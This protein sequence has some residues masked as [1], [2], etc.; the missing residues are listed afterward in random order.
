VIKSTPL[1]GRCIKRFR[2][3]YSPYWPTG[4]QHPVFPTMALHC[5]PNP[6]REK[7]SRGP[8]RS[9]HTNDGKPPTAWADV[10]VSCTTRL[11]HC[12]RMPRDECSGREGFANHVQQ[13]CKEGVR[14]ILDPFRASISG[15]F[16]FG[17]GAMT[18][19]RWS[20]L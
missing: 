16:R 15:G 7:V 9:P 6:T 18:P 13:P 12:A 1:A 4:F 2:Y 11:D 14:Q 17:A 5:R 3:P 19:R 8:P 20:T 10:N